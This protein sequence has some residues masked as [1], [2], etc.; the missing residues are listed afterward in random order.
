[1]SPE[2]RI[3]EPWFSKN[4]DALADSIMP[5]KPAPGLTLHLAGD[6]TMSNK[7]DAVFAERG[8]GQALRGM[9][10][11][12]VGLANFAV[13]GRSTKSFRMLGH[14]DHLLEAARPG[15]IAII[16]F[17]HNDANRSRPDRYVSPAEYGQRISRFIDELVEIGAKPIIATPICRRRFENGELVP[18]H[19]D[20]PAAAKAVADAKNVP[21]ID[22]E[23]LTANMLS[24]YGE[25]DSAA[26]FLPDNTHL[27]ARGA[28][29]HANLAVRAINELNLGVTLFC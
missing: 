9:M 1:E 18:T 3:S 13:N 27:N 11:P 23:R 29:E 7:E 14:W 16:Q 19:G 21:L 25:V 24:N 6:S 2:H 17:G 20:Y 8:W 28:I 4:F 12:G 15:D 5:H 10:A 22:M 26:L